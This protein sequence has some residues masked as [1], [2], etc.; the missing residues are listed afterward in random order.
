[1]Y[2]V[3]YVYMFVCLVHVEGRK[4]EEDARFAL[5]IL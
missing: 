1:V 5:L 2:G 3:T 4:L